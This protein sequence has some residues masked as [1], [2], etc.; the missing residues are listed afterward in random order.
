MKPCFPSFWPTKWLGQTQVCAFSL[1]RWERARII[2][3]RSGVVSLA[4]KVDSLHHD[5]FGWLCPARVQTRDPTLNHINGK[6]VRCEIRTNMRSSSGR[7]HNTELHNQAAQMCPS[8]WH[9]LLLRL[10]IIFRLPG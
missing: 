3:L 6:S 8:P 9:A 4:T 2:T 5:L 1:K 10:K 7:H